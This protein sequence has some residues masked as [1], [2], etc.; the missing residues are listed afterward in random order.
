[1]V[2]TNA[3]K[4]LFFPNMLEKNSHTARRMCVLLYVAL[5]HS[6]RLIQAMNRLVTDPGFV[7]IVL[8]NPALDCIIPVMP[9]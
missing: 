4:R 7:Q 5:S 8:V 9:D 3:T 6:R 2:S 1:M